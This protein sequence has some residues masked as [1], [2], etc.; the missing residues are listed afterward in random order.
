MASKNSRQIACRYPG[1]TAHN[2]DDQCDRL[3]AGIRVL[4]SDYEQSLSA[5][6]KAPQH[7]REAKCRNDHFD[8]T[9]AAA[10]EGLIPCYLVLPRDQQARMK[11]ADQKACMTRESKDD[12]VSPMSSPEPQEWLKE[13]RLLPDGGLREG[14]LVI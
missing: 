11:L 7:R 5:Q 6:S 8:A 13:A 14:G 10:Q 1:I 4:L 9:S 2:C 3:Y 12:N